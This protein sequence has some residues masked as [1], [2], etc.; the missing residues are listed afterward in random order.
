[1]VKRAAVLLHVCVTVMSVNSVWVCVCGGVACVVGYLNHHTGW[2][3]KNAIS[4]IL[5]N[6]LPV[7]EGRRKALRLGRDFR[8]PLVIY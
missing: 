2:R 5:D 1:M 3:P 8:R 4:R 6:R 7:R